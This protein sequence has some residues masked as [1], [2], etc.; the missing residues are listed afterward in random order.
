M[1]PGRISDIMIFF[2]FVKPSLSGKASPAKTEEPKLE[3]EGSA[4]QTA[5]M[6]QDFKAKSETTTLSSLKRLNDQRRASLHKGKN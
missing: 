1:C 5:A 3:A 2:F 4:T 6:R